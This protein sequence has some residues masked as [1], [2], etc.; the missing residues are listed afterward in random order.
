[1]RLTITGDRKD[2]YTIVA[3][4]SALPF[5]IESRVTTINEL[6]T[7]VGRLLLQVFGGH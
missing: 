7:K 4:S 5:P 2:G 1:M 3:E 6:I